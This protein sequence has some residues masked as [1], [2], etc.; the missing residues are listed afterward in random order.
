MVRLEIN[1]GVVKSD[2]RVDKKM[3]RNIKVT[4]GGSGR[5]KIWI[6]GELVLCNWYYVTAGLMLPVIMEEL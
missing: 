1:T 6:I 5:D 2:E 4:L 3:M